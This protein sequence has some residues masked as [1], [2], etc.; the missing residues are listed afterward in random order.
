MERR[1]WR[2]SAAPKRRA[3][4]NATSAPAPARARAPWRRAP[5]EEGTDHDEPH[6]EGTHRDERIGP[7]G[8]EKP[9]L[10]QVVP[11]SR[12]RITHATPAPNAAFEMSPARQSPNEPATINIA[13]GNAR[14]TVSAQLRVT[15]S[16]SMSPHRHGL[17]TIRRPTTRGGARTVGKRT[18][19]PGPK[20]PQGEKRSPGLAAVRGFVL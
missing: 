4:I 20:D 19:P 1:C 3:P 8:A 14:I 17:C 7:V 2:G 6:E 10:A 12:T 13:D 5:D 11:P 15:R 16:P 18:T 9:S